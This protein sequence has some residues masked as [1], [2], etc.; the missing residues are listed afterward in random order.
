MIHAR[1]NVIFLHIILNISSR[2]TR[3]YFT[4]ISFFSKE[5]IENSRN[6][7]SPAEN[8]KHD[9]VLITIE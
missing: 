9:T 8:L 4:R 3:F 6:E 5:R 7:S 1:K 2:F